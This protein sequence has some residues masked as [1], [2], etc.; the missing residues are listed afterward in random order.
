MSTSS[1]I[2]FKNAAL[3]VFPLILTRSLF[4]L[5]LLGEFTW[6]G[7][8]AG[9]VG[10]G[11]VVGTVKLLIWCCCCR[12]QLLL[13]SLLHWFSILGWG[14]QVLFGS[15]CT[16]PFVF[17]LHSQRQTGNSLELNLSA[18]SCRQ[19]DDYSLRPPGQNR[20]QEKCI[21]EFCQFSHCPLYTLSPNC[22]SWP[23]FSSPWTT[24]GS[25]G[26]EDKPHHQNP[27]SVSVLCGF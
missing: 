18:Y 23:S 7:G 2:A 15:S 11:L 19:G 8:N 16:L 10:R 21:I 25:G 3:C 9:M 24:L 1:Y 6:T 27:R 4:L 26:W 22:P 5:C 20:K 12:A 13:L 17:W 14:G